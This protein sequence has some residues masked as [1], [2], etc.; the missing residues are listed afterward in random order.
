MLPM[1]S[2]PLSAQKIIGIQTTHIITT[3]AKLKKK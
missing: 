1:T 2:L 3:G